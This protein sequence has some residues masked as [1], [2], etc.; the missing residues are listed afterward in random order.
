MWLEQFTSFKRKSMN[1]LLTTLPACV[2]F[3]LRA[4]IVF[5]LFFL[6]WSSWILC[7]QKHFFSASLITH[8]YLMATKKRQFHSTSF[9]PVF[10]FFSK[11]EH[12]CLSGKRDKTECCFF[13]CVCQTFFSHRHARER[14]KKKTLEKA[15]GL[16]LWL[17]MNPQKYVA[18]VVKER[19]VIFHPI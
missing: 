2:I 17:H 3:W 16:S 5:C 14:K 10:F 19:S 4:M 1:R 11:L 7:V 13:I 18:A 12:S 15:D 8:T 9:F 6:P